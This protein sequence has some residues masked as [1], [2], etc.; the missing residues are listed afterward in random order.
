MLFL[1]IVLS[2]TQGYAGS[3]TRPDQVYTKIEKSPKEQGF[4]QKTIPKNNAKTVSQFQNQL[5]LR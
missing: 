2:I 5:V 3:P 1:I 4:I